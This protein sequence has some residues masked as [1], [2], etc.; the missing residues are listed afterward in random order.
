[1]SVSSIGPTGS[2][3]PPTQAQPVGQAG[4]LVPDATAPASS[5][6]QGVTQPTTV[7]ASVMLA[8]QERAGA[9]AGDQE[10]RQHGRRLLEALAELQRALLSGNEADTLQEL[11]RLSEEGGQA[12]DPALA[13]VIRSIRLRA[14]LELARAAKTTDQARG[15][16]S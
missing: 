6:L 2:L 16:G 1:M 14:R 8:L 12:V 13:Q 7:G 15:S 10:A 3:R 11:L 5:N 4:F 9:E